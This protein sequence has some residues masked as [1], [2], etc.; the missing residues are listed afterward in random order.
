MS[1]RIY[2]SSTTD[3][4]T[5]AASTAYGLLKFVIPSTPN[6]Y[7]YECISKGISN[8]EEPTWPTTLGH[9]VLDGETVVV[10]EVEELVNPVTWA[11]R[12]LLAPDP[13]SVELD[14]GG[15]G[16]YALKDIWI[17]SSNDEGVDNFIVYGSHDGDNW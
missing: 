14:T 12:S 11:C 10:D 2:R 17:R 9:T 5:W 7:C 16:G 13:L 15:Q 4:P 1:I 3:H 6:G 8:S